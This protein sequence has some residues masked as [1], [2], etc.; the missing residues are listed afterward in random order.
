MKKVLRIKKRL[1]AK[2]YC[3]KYLHGQICP[4]T[5]RQIVFQA[6]LSNKNE[7][8]E[9]EPLIGLFHKNWEITPI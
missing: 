1:P 9:R 3:S 6:D 5:R 7:K 2:M 8:T 4:K